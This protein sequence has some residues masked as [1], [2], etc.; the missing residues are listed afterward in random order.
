VK[1]GDTVCILNDGTEPVITGT[2]IK[3]ILKA[4]E[5]GYNKVI[6]VSMDNNKIVIIIY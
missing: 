1:A 3:D 6:K 2:T 4:L 5:R